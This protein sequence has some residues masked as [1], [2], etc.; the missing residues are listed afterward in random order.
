MKR[1]EFYIISLVALAVVT[2][3]EFTAA[4]FDLGPPSVTGYNWLIGFVTGAYA[5]GSKP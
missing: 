2:G 1:T 3:M 5:I 4:S